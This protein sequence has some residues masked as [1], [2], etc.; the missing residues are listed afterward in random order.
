[1][2]ESVDREREQ[3]EHRGCWLR[4]DYL[5]VANMPLPVNNRSSS[6]GKS[7]GR[8]WNGGRT[9]VSDSDTSSSFE[10]GSRSS[11]SSSWRG[12][13]LSRWRCQRGAGKQSYEQTRWK[14]TYIKRQAEK[15]I[16]IDRE[17]ERERAQ[18][19]RNG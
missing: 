11:S 14:V 1:M 19:D 8:G 7:R 3:G 10:R 9:D 6:R 17:R 18:S 16:E 12:S 5:L 13:K 15:E 4:V 2:C